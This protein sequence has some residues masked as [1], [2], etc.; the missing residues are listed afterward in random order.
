MICILLLSSV[1]ILSAIFYNKILNAL[2]I[3]TLLF[4]LCLGLLFGAD[5]LFKNNYSNF[6]LTKELSCVALGFIIFYGGFCTKWNNAKLILEEACLLSTLGV[7]FTAI[8]VGLFCHYIL[9]INYLESFL[10]G[11]VICSTDAASV[12]SILKS[13]SLNLKENTTSLLELESG[14]NDPMS[15]ILVILAITLM[16]GENIHTIIILFFKQ[17]MIGGLTGFLIAKFAL[18]FFQKTTMI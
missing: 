18:Y 10:F 5:A 4:F 16:Q 14:S 9:K 7:L 11:S 6:E 8:I 12:F 3:P 1:V 15:Y 13:K 2:G 17:I